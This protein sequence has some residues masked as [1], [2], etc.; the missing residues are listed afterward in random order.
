MV[1]VSCGSESEMSAPLGKISRSGTTSV[2]SGV[3]PA[4]SM[5]VAAVTGLNVEPGSY[6]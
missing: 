4:A 2:D 6:E 5:A 1:S 3:R